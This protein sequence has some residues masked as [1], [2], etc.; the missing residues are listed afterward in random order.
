MSL[1][2]FAA[3]SV[4]HLILLSLKLNIKYDFL[5]KLLLFAF[6]IVFTQW[7]YRFINRYKSSKILKFFWQKK[8]KII[9]NFDLCFRMCF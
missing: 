3:Q 6:P 1:N 5:H 2:R 7:L 4:F 8:Q 9:F